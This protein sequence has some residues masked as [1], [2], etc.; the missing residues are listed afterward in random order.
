VL[1]LEDHQKSKSEVRSR[2]LSFPRV[3]VFDLKSKLSF[4][5]GNVFDLKSKLSF[6][7]GNVFDLKSKLSFPRGNVFDLNSKL[8]LAGNL[9]STAVDL[10]CLRTHSSRTQDCLSGWQVTCLT[11]LNVCF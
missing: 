4:P 6:P 7:R 9:G 2:K 11:Y 5:R 3:N 1:I 8:A 10:A